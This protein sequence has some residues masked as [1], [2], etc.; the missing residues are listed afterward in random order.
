MKKLNSIE[1]LIVS[2]Q[3]STLLGA[4]LPLLDAINLMQMPE[5]A[6]NLKKD[7]PYLLHFKS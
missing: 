4:G 1:Q 6:N 5:V 7:A 3:V 2:K